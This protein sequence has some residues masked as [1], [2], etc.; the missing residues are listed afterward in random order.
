MPRSGAARA[1]RFTRENTG[2]EI[3]MAISSAAAAQCLTRCSRQATID[4]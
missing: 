3:A 4:Y 1:T 2:A